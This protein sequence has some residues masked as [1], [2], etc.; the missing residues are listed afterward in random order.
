VNPQKQNGK[1]PPSALKRTVRTYGRRRHKHSK[2]ERPTDIVCT[3]FR[4]TEA[5]RLRIE[6]AADTNGRSMNAEMTARL[7]NSFWLDDM[8]KAKLICELPEMTAAVRK[9]KEAEA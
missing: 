3:M 4:S 9:R 5:L 7:E 8:L 2:A 6:Q 1:L